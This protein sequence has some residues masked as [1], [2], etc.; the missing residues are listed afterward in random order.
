M[1]YIMYY[2]V[3]KKQDSIYRNPQ[4]YK[5]SKKHIGTDVLNVLSVKTISSTSTIHLYNKHN[6]HYL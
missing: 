2:T 5:K 4:I 6:N 3:S 1:K